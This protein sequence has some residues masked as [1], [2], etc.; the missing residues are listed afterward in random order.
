MPVAGRAEHLEEPQ[1]LGSLQPLLPEL[2]DIYAGRQHG[3]KEPDQVAVVLPGIGTQVQARGRE[4]VMQRIGI[5][6][7]GGLH[8]AILSLRPIWPSGGRRP[9]APGRGTPLLQGGRGAAAPAARVAQDARG[10]K[11]SAWARRL[12]SLQR[13]AAIASIGL[14]GSESSSVNNQRIASTSVKPQSKSK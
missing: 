3:V 2:H 14:P 1:F 4:P 5:D 7:G 10:Q 9:G 13:C 6:V 11:A 12:T 8:V